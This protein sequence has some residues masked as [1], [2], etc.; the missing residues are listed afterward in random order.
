MK[1]WIPASRTGMTPLVVQV[2]L[3]HNTCTTVYQRYQEL[4]FSFII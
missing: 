3:K 2:A 1:N 4:A